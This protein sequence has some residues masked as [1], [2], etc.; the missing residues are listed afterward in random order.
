MGTHPQYEDNWI[1]RFQRYYSFLIYASTDVYNIKY[2]LL[3][4]FFFIYIYNRFY[5]NSDV[6]VI[7]FM[8]VCV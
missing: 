7:L 5:C 3:I 2:I 8:Y 6:Y 1:I 4:L